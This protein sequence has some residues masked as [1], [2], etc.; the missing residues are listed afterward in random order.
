[1]S[2]PVRDPQ[3]PTHPGAKLHSIEIKEEE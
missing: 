1:M 2:I 3:R